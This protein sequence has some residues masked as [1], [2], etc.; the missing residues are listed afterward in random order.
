ML[1]I[2]FC[3]IADNFKYIFRFSDFFEIDGKHDF[4]QNALVFEARARV[5]GCLVNIPDNG[6]GDYLQVLLVLERFWFV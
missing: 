4:T 5:W 3:I 2:S 1:N 6:L